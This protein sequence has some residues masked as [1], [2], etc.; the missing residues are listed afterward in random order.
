MVYYKNGTIKTESVY[1]DKINNGKCP[2]FLKRISFNKEG[3][4]TFYNVVGKEDGYEKSDDGRL[5]FS[6]SYYNNIYS[7]KEYFDSG[8]IKVESFK[9]YNPKSDDY[10]IKTGLWK[11]YNEDGYLKKTETYVEGKLIKK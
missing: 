5:K 2:K 6:W 10:D 7:E 4:V 3:E 11:Y 1:E 8:K 9:K